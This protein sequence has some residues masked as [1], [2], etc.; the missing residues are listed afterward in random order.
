MS[1]WDIVWFI[2]ISF[3]FMAYLMVMFAIITDLFRDPKASGFA[4]AVWF[5]ALIFLPFITSVVYL[6]SKGSEMSE[7]QARG[8]QQA[9]EQQD[10]YIK[11]VASSS[12]PTE[13][14]AQAKSMLDSGAITTAEFER[15]KEK[16]L[17]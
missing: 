17:A 12:A 4:K 15:L 16:A 10:A 9:R 6:I 3:A 2:L 11:Q 5:I 8:V 1:F 14:I 7:R 13:Q